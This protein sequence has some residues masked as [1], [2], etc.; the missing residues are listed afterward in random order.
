MNAVAFEAVT[1]RS[2]HL[3]DGYERVDPAYVRYRSSQ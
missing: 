3:S 2:E 1:Q